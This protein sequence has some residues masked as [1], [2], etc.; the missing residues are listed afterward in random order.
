[1]KE[2]LACKWDIATKK[3]NL[4]LWKVEEVEPIKKKLEVKGNVAIVLL[5]PSS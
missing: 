1:M 5:E 3:K 2:L 4:K